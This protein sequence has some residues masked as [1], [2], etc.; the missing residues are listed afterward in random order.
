MV[1]IEKNINLKALNSFHI[2]ANAKYLCRITHLDQLK[3]LMAMDIYQSEKH[4]IL[5]GG[6]NILLTKDFD[7]LLIKVE[8]KGLEKKE[9]SDSA[10]KIKVSAGENWHQL[11]EYAVS[12][13]WGGIENLSLIPGT[14][15]A[16][17]MQNIGAYGVEIKD[18]VSEVEAINLFTGTTR[19]F[20]NPECGFGYRESVFKRSL[21]E[22]FFISSVTLTL[23]T[24]NHRLNTSYGTL[25]ETLQKRNV[26]HITIQEIS[27][28]VIEIRKSKLPDPN[29]IGNAGSFYKNPTIDIDKYKILT[30][31]HGPMPSYFIDNQHVKVPAGWLIEQCGWK[32]KR[33]NHI[34][35]HPVQALVLVNYDQGSGEEILQLAEEIQQSV[36]E[37]FDIALTPEVNIL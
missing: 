13:Q 14:V 30:A 34:G 31:L 18:V 8:L 36:F 21:K 23:T 16:A 25:H 10:V 7:G 15:G 9:E 19:V 22:I 29:E 2:D 28:A 24:N 5:G 32:G 27:R 12:Q 11:V 6:T 35:V 33:I 4:Y 37:K 20:A 1:P 3:E 26:D 17:P